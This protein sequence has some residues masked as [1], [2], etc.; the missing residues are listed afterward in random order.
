MLNK[1]ILGGSAQ[2]VVTMVVSEW[3]DFFFYPVNFSPPFDLFKSR[4]FVSLKR[5]K[6]GCIIKYLHQNQLCQDVKGERKGEEGGEGENREK[7]R[8]DLTKERAGRRD[9]GRGRTGRPEGGGSAWRAT[10]RRAENWGK[11]GEGR[12]EESKEKGRA[13]GRREKPAALGGQGESLAAC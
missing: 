6:M 1:N 9:E 3:W 7:G 10:Q 13:P 2:P 12:E 4:H 8:G 5:Q 11:E